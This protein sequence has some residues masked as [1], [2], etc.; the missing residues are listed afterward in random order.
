M[1]KPVYIFIPAIKLSNVSQNTSAQN[2]NLYLC[3]SSAASFNI[4]LPRP[5]QNHIV[6]IK[7]ATHSFTHKPVTVKRYANEKIE[8]AATDYVLNTDG[9]AVS[10]ISDGTDWWVA[11]Q[12][13][14]GIA[15]ALSG[16]FANFIALGAISARDSVYL[17]APGKVSKADVSSGGGL[18]KSQII[19]FS[20]ET[21]ADGATV[22]IQF[23]GALDGFGTLTPGARYYGDPA[24]LGGI[25]STKPV[26]S[27]ST[28]VQV[29]Y[30]RTADR[31]GIMIQQLG[32]NA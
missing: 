4:T 14:E 26:A 20:T 6:M 15:A 27:G 19:G 29:G 5:V 1:L 9:D 28:I 32:R 24:V 10:F 8:F 17:S 7:D 22:V 31:L 25:T 30:A 16:S 13:N 18:T 3:D 21:V 23:D 11:T 12:W 2:G